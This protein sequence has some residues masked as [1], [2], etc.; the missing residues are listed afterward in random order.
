MAAVAQLKAM[1]K[2]DNRQYKAG[3]RDSTNATKSFQ[4]TLATVGGSIAAAFSV[5]AIINFGRRL[6]KLGSDMSDLALQAGLTTDQYQALEFASLRAGVQ[7]EQIRTI[8]SKLNVVM[9]Q[10]KRG[11]KTYVDMFKA[12]GLSVE[13]LK[14]LSVPEV[15][16]QI[17]VAMSKAERGTETFGAGLEL[18]GTRSGAKFIQVLNE[19]SE[20]GLAGLEKE[21]RS[22]FGYLDED[23]IQTLD[24][25]EDSILKLQRAFAGLAAGPLAKVADLLERFYSRA[26]NAEKVMKLFAAMAGGPASSA[27]ANKGIEALSEPTKKNANAATPPSKPKGMMDLSVFD[28]PSQ[29]D[30]LYSNLYTDSPAQDKGLK[31]K[32]DKIMKAAQDRIAA[33]KERDMMGIGGSGVSVSGMEQMGGFVGAGRAGV[34]QADRQLNVAKENKRIA[35][36]ALKIHNKALEQLKALNQKA[37]PSGTV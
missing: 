37:Q 17:A 6:T 13:D 34:G 15:L 31:T 36:E 11:M 1:L 19:I 27:L 7:T 20:K 3:V 9:G 5:G 8:M 30:G 18:I 28:L 35:A 29:D 4:S 22:T 14:R 12:V 16:E 2:M 32:Q 33:L 21:A 26:G 25:L 10:A 24:Q 23:A